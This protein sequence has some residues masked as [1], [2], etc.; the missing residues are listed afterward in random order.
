MLWSRR[1]N[2][3]CT[4]VSAG[5]PKSIRVSSRPF[6]AQLH[7]E[8]DG[9]NLADQRLLV[10]IQILQCVHGLIGKA[11]QAIDVPLWEL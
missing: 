5:R 9:L 7:L 4:L 2:R 8:L 1:G 11:D 3:E 6:A 10:R